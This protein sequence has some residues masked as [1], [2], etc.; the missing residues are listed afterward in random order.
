[1]HLPITRRQDLV[2]DEDG[3]RHRK[4]KASDLD[5]STTIRCAETD[6]FTKME[7][8]NQLKC[9]ND[10]QEGQRRMES[11]LTSLPIKGNAP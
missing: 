1:M 3:N 4:H 7:S 8:F 10:T 6:I 9:A 11:H 5:D 2:S